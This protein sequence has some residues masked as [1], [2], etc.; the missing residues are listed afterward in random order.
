MPVAWV[1]MLVACFAPGREWCTG[2]GSAANRG[3]SARPM[4]MAFQQSE[5]RVLLQG[6]VLV[7]AWSLERDED[8]GPLWITLRDYDHAHVLFEWSVPE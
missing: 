8:D 5:P 2:A 7:L 4:S 6:T 3:V 1:L